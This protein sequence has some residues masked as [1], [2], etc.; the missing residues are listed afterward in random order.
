MCATEGVGGSGTGPF[1]ITHLFC[2]IYCSSLTFGIVVLV[3]VVPSWRHRHHCAAHLVSIMVS[4]VGAKSSV[5]SVSAAVHSVC[6]LH[7]SCHATLRAVVAGAGARRPGSVSGGQ[8]VKVRAAN[9]AGAPRTFICKRN[10]QPLVR[11]LA[12]RKSLNIQR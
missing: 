3:S 7:P 4:V 6:P 8:E 9:L 2:S 5:S 1:C 10:P 12:K 11:T